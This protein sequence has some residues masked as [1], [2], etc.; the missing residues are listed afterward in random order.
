MKPILSICIPNYNGAKNIQRAIKSCNNVNL[1]HDEFEI[2]VVDN[3]STDNSLGVV[4]QLRETFPNVFVHK[5]SANIG[6]VE[7]WNKCI[8]LARGRYLMFL[9]ANEEVHE[10]ADLKTDV[11]MLEQNHGVSLI[12]KDIDYRYPDYCYRLF[13]IPGTHCFSLTAYTDYFLRRR[14]LFICFGIPQQMI[15][16]L[17]TLREHGLR[18][19]PTLAR[20]ADRVFNFQV[21]K[22][23]IDSSFI[24][25]NIP[26]VIWNLDSGRFHFQMHQSF[27][28]LDFNSIWAQEFSAN[29]AIML[30]LGYSEFEILNIH[31]SQCISIKLYA[32]LKGFKNKEQVLVDMFIGYLKA[33]SR[34]NGVKTNF[35]WQIGMLARKSFYLLFDKKFR[36]LVARASTI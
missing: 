25:R 17:S 16:R 21:M 27:E 35:F 29:R 13:N 8:D 34:I 23:S 32:K 22:A 6:R 10:E 12:M 3:A 24:Y 33:Y 9:F 36:L 14:L 11:D 7:N 28:N 4:E 19:D 2:L 30:E 26:N 15:F 1:N 20:T 18:Y 31:L 5:N